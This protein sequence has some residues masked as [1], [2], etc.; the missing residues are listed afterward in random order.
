MLKRFLFE[1]RATRIERR[2][3]H[4]K[5]QDCHFSLIGKVQPKD[6]RKRENNVCTYSHK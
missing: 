2:I 6:D 4:P 3:R 5:L 1:I